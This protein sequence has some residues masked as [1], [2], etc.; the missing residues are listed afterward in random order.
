MLIIS[1]CN[2]LKIYETIKKVKDILICTGF[3]IM[4]EANLF[5]KNSIFIGHKQQVL[6]LFNRYILFEKFFKERIGSTAKEIQLSTQ[7]NDTA[8]EV[9]VSTSVT[10]E[11][12]ARQQ[13]VIDARIKWIVTLYTLGG[14]L[15]CLGNIC[16]HLVYALIESTEKACVRGL[17]IVYL[18]AF[19]EGLIFSFYLVRAT[20]L[21]QGTAFEISKCRQYFFGIAPTVSLSIV[22]FVYNLRIQLS[23][24]SE[25]GL[26]A[27]LLFFLVIFVNI[28]WNAVLF[29]FLIYHVH[30]VKKVFSV[31]VYMYIY[32]S[33]CVLSTLCFIGMFPPPLVKK[34][35]IANGAMTNHH[36][37]KDLKEYL[38]KLLQL[39]LITELSA[40]ALYAT[41]LMS[42][43]KDA[44]WSLAVIDVCVNC[45]AIL[46]SF[47]F[48]ELQKMFPFLYFSF[49]D[50][51]AYLKRDF[52]AIFLSLFKN[53]KKTSDVG[54]EKFKNFMI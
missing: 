30:K 44:L 37:Q 45:S 43:W 18:R 34:K 15:S 1:F 4:K 17:Y 50:E 47:D 29:I 9:S 52:R 40:T 7:K 46:L 20:I 8:M 13:V 39:F 42:S 36:I 23:H 11:Q 10:L 2:I 24:C 53:L 33:L 26:A 48:F 54:S 5:S 16:E 19:M 49:R 51:T 3:N 41:I 25:A 6:S 31:C 28:F 35:K 14:F 38:K 27:L 22:L 12:S 32:E 21:L